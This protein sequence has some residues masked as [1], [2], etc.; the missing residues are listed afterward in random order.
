MIDAWE[1]FTP[2][3]SSECVQTL[4]W[5]WHDNYVPL[6]YTSQQ[7]VSAMLLK[8]NFNNIAAISWRSVLLP[9]LVEG[10][11][12]PGER[13][14]WPA[15]SH[16]QTLSHNVVSSTPRLFQ[17]RTQNVSGDRHIGYIVV[18]PTTHTITTTTSFKFKLTVGDTN[19]I[20]QIKKVSSTK[21]SLLRTIC[22]HIL[23]VTWHWKKMI[24]YQLKEDA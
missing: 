11:G 15:A 21:S 4:I 19:I 12:V 5:K 24:S 23:I 7:W 16:W 1:F 9:I 22:K 8:A 2:V 14:H 10:T 13:E 6:F 17:I 20:V 18:N 3:Y